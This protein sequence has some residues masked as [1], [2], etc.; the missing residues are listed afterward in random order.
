MG[1]IVGIVLPTSEC[2]EFGVGKK[3][4]QPEFVTTIFTISPFFSPQDR[5]IHQLRLLSA[6]S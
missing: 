6:L 3:G 2:C 1:G 5:E 4:A